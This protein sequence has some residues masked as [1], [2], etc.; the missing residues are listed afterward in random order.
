MYILQRCKPYGALRKCRFCGYVRCVVICAFVLFR[1]MA[2]EAAAVAPSSGPIQRPAL[3][4][5][6][7]HATVKRNLVASIALAIG[8]AVI[9]KFTVGDP[10]KQAYADFY[11]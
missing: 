7:H 1:D 6:L 9:F 3:L 2:G 10:R 11:K 8:A 4:K 5:G